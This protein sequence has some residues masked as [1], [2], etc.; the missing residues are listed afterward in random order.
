MRQQGSGLG[1]AV[2][3]GDVARRGGDT[4]QFRAIC[5][6]QPGCG[7][8]VA[9]RMRTV[10]KHA[11]ERRVSRFHRPGHADLAKEQVGGV[12]DLGKPP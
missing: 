12:G 7:E 5:R 11:A 10:G 6:C 3:G 9:L 1:E 2:G 8:R 4:P